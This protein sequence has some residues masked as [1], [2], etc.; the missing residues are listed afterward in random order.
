MNID[1][2]LEQIISKLRTGSNSNKYRWN[3]KSIKQIA[4]EAYK[5]GIAGRGDAAAMGAKNSGCNFPA[6]PLSNERPAEPSD[7]A[8]AAA[9]DIELVVSLWLSG[10]GMPPTDEAGKGLL[11]SIMA[12]IIDKRFSNGA[13]TTKGESK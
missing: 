11:I 7:K 10:M 6:P 12:Q 2:K 3:R 4:V 13:S 8:K 9:K 5:L 1:E